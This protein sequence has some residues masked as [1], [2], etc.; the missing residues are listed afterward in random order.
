M[1]LSEV[2]GRVDAVFSPLLE[3]KKCGMCFDS[4]HS[5]WVFLKLPFSPFLNYFSNPK[6]IFLQFISQ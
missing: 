5:I 2:E 3:N 1:S 6:C 4:G